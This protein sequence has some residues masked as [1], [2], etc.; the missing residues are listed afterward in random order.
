[1]TAAAAG[2]WASGG[3]FAQA[4][5]LTAKMIP[6]P[7]IIPIMAKHRILCIFISPSLIN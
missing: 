2:A 4:K 5:K 3:F 1:V 6:S 7:E